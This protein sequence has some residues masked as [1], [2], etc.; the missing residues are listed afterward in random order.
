MAGRI[1]KRKDVSTMSI[2]NQS[3]ISRIK[4]GSDEVPNY[5]EPDVSKLYPIG[6]LLLREDDY[7][8]NKSSYRHSDK[9][10]A[11]PL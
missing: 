4:D 5:T 9:E 7:F 3:Q 10:V 8:H 2:Q 11:V 6:E 1:V